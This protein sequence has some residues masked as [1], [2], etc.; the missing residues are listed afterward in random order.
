MPNAKRSI[1]SAPQKGKSRERASDGEADSDNERASRRQFDSGYC[2]HGWRR[3][4]TVL[5]VLLRMGDQYGF[6]AMGSGPKL[7][8]HF[9]MGKRD[10]ENAWRFM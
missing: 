9:R 1:G 2:S 4:Q 5:R 6:V 3:T 8:P 10:S 7:I